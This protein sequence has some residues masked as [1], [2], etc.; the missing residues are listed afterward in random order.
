MRLI[1]FAVVLGVSPGTLHAQLGAGAD[2]AALAPLFQSDDILSLTLS[3]PLS[4]L[5]RNRGDDAPEFP[6]QLTVASPDGQPRTLDLAIQLR[7][8][9]RRS[10]SVCSFPPIRLDFPKDSVAGT[11]FEGQNRLKLVT[12]CRERD[13]YEQYVVMEYLLYRTLNAITDVSFRVRL[14]QMTYRDSEQ[15]G[16][17]PITRLG[18]LI[19]DDDDLAA[20][21]GFQVLSLPAIN[22]TD[23]DPTELANVE[24]FQYL[25][26]NTDF[27]AFRHATGQEECCHNAKL[28]GHPAGPVFSV[29]YDFDYAGVIDARYAVVSEKL[30]IRGVTER[31]YRGRCWPGESWDRTIRLF[32]EKRETIYELFRRQ[33][34]LEPERLKRTLEYF[35]EFYDTIDDARQTARAIMRTCVPLS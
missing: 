12:H 17:D 18:F 30:P 16:D 13:E 6:A 1:T 29:P 32:R 3:A 20:R 11:L 4:T 28:I 21:L 24:L 26:G 34:Q 15:P 27:S 5:F 31:L 8:I 25:I 35:D 33:P 10:R 19:E 2:S 23:L 7:G 22:P 14:A 9:T